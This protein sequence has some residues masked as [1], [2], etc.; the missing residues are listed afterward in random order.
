MAVVHRVWIDPPFRPRLHI[1]LSLPLESD[2]VIVCVVIL[3]QPPCFVAYKV[4]AAHYLADYYVIFC[5]LKMRVFLSFPVKKISVVSYFIHFWNNFHKLTYS[6]LI[7]F[8][9]WSHSP[10]PSSLVFSLFLPPPHPRSTTAVASR[11]K[12]KQHLFRAVSPKD[13]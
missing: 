1:P 9:R 10:L 3:C 7:S 5:F 12:F 13:S 4:H 6:E 11:Q 8:R 2:P